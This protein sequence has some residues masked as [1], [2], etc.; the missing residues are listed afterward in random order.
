[1][2]RNRVPIL[3]WLP[4]Y[5]TDIAVA[6]LIAGVTV[7]LTVMPQALA[8]AALAGLPPQ[9]GL[10][11]S[12]I[13]CFVYTIFGSCKDIT[14]GPTALMSLMTNQQV[15]G[16]NSDYAILLCFLTG[17]V[18]IVMSCMRLGVLVEFISQPVT[19]GFTTATSVIIV[20]SQLKGLLG[21]SYESGNFLWT[22]QQFA[23][24]VHKTRWPDA[25]LGFSCIAILLFLRKV[26]DLYV[27]DKLKSSK[28]ERV[29]A[30]SL[31]LLSTSRNALMVIFCSVLA[32]VLENNH[33]SAPF[34]ITGNVRSGIP[35]FQLPPFSTV[36]ENRTVSFGEM[37]SDLGSSIILVPVIAVLG[38]VAIA[39]A[40][41]G[42]EPVDATQELLT[43]AGCNLFGS[44]VS[45]M[46]VT[47]SFS[48]SAVNHASGVKTTMGG[49][50]TGVLLLLALGVLTPYFYYIPKASLAAVIICAVI[51]MIEYEVVKPMWRASKRDILPMLVTFVVCLISSVEVGILVGVGVN[52]ALLLIYSARP[53]IVTS[54][55]QCDGG[56]EYISIKPNASVYFP[57][58]EYLRSTVITAGK[59]KLPIVFDCTLFEN[60]DFTTAKGISSLINDFKKRH[61]PLFFYNV[62]PSLAAVLEPI[63][64]KNFM[65][66]SVMDDLVQAL[67]VVV[68]SGGDVDEVLHVTTEMRDVSL[69]HRGHAEPSEN[70]EPLLVG[71]K[72]AAIVSST[73]TST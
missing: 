37:V 5:N 1:M 4:K 70:S 21:L 12:F 6:D 16:R 39:K 58:M 62:Q 36:L 69:Y 56:V 25:V 73:L 55:L 43:L 65:Y 63:C 41:A 9:Y 20:A 34:K 38:N 72:R 19:V 7:G 29:I 10:Y 33:G 40:F 18:L 54:H 48:R 60:T 8:Y 35:P 57:G 22:L 2:V 51:F 23:N 14:I 3:N 30:K 68:K 47:G 53:K 44:F 59:S 11:S 17:V 46:P 71:Q 64:S 32:Y 24:N 26:K 28:N 66:Y 15:V 61:Q 49:V 50:F 67:N 27:I 42:G 31:W 13:G 45:S 52:I